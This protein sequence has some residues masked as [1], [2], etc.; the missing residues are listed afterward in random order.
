M[1]SRHPLFPPCPAH[2]C[3][4]EDYAG[5]FYEMIEARLDLYLESLGEHLVKK[6]HLIAKE[7]RDPFILF[8]APN[9]YHPRLDLSFADV[10]DF[11]WTLRPTFE[12]LL[13]EAT[14]QYWD[15]LSNK[16]LDTW[17]LDD[18]QYRA[19]LPSC[20][21]HIWTSNISATMKDLT[22]TEQTMNLIIPRPFVLTH[23][24]GPDT[25]SSLHQQLITDYFDTPHT[26]PSEGSPDSTLAT[27][28]YSSGFMCFRPSHFSASI[29]KNNTTTT[30]LHI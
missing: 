5:D 17:P 4:D 24:K 22:R 6:G 28:P 14:Y 1:E 3:C 29:P 25:N 30:E 7:S 19:P 21:R 9:F 13:A 2:C 18:C 12:N 15:T 26:S 20:I 10:T 23:S 16:Y 8:C 27:A 11:D